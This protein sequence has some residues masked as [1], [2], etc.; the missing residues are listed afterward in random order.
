MAAV[1]V[2][3]IHAIDEGKPFAH[4]R[5]RR[6]AKLF[7]EGLNI[8]LCLLEILRHVQSSS[9]KDIER[10]GRGNWLEC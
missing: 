6:R 3:N 5:E 8:P 10:P 9:P 2:T 7:G 4:E 1:V